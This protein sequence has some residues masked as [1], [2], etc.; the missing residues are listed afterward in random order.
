MNLRLPLVLVNGKLNELPSGDVLAAVVAS[1]SYS[2]TSSY[3]LNNTGSSGSS[4]N[5]IRAD[6][7]E[8]IPSTT[9]GCGIDS[10]ETS[11]FRVNRDFL[12][13]DPATTEFAQY[14]FNWPSGWN[15]ATVTFFWIVNTAGTGS[16][17]WEASMI[18]FP[19]SSSSDIQFTTS[20]S[21]V[22]SAWTLPNY[23]MAS[24]PTSNIYPITQS[25]AISLSAG[26][27]VVL[28]VWRDSTNSSDTNPF[29]ALLEGV[30][31]KQGT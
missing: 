4:L 16:V 7:S 11:V 8:F 28:Q 18:G 9:N 2:V 12:T 1:A 6:A 15:S 31:I 5:A 22:D 25:S 21:V 23:M 19:D 29:D 17:V 14:W 30:L 24:S 26:D 27:R 3:S 13:F 10:Q 20:Q